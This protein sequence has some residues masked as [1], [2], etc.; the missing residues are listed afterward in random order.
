MQIEG[1]LSRLRQ[2]LATEGPLK[3]IE[4]A[5]DF[6]FKALFV[7]KILKFLSRPFGPVEKRLD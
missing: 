5:F 3:I 7:L 4:N 1:A 2:F 6:T